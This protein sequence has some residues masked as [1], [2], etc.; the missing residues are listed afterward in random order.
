M[1]QFTGEG[2]R[3]RRWRVVKCVVGNTVVS[4]Q[5]GKH[6]CDIARQ[7]VAAS[8]KIPTTKLLRD[9]DSAAAISSPLLNQKQLAAQ[10]AL[11]SLYQA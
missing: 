2:R 9:V 3:D 10:T 7:L 5:K 8:P 6:R 4:R 11:I 1:P